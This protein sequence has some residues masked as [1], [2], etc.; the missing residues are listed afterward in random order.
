[1]SNSTTARQGGRRQKTESLRWMSN[2]KGL[3]EEIMQNDQTKIMRIPLGET[4]L[5]LQKVGKRAIEL[6]DPELN[7]LMIRLSLYSINDPDSPDFNSIKAQKYLREEEKPPARQKEGVET[8][9]E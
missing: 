9:H 3:F 4:Y 8:G 1:L 7:C 2:V 6:N 5:L